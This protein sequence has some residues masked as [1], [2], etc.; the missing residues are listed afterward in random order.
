M[1]TE[2]NDHA[3]PE[4]GGEGSAARGVFGGRDL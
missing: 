4:P 1:S 3:V 2:G